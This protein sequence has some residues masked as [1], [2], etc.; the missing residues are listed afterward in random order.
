MSAMWR[1]CRTT[2]IETIANLDEEV[3]RELLEIVEGARS[4][5]GPGYYEVHLVIIAEH[6]SEDPDNERGV[7]AMSV[8]ECDGLEDG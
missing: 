2:F 4:G 6:Y 8:T 5:P 1:W 7:I 3:A